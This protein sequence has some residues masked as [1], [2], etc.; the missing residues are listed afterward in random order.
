LVRVLGGGI[1]P[2]VHP[3]RGRENQAVAVPRYGKLQ[4][5]TQVDSLKG[6]RR[7]VA[8]LI[9]LDTPRSRVMPCIQDPLDVLGHPRHD[10][11]GQQREGAG[12]RYEFLLAPAPCRG[13]APEVDDP[14]QGMNRLAVVKDPEDLTAKGWVA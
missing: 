3:G 5:A 2:L 6:H 10:D 1:R 4:H 13:N 7:N 11:V 9:P 14:L 8:Q 12:D